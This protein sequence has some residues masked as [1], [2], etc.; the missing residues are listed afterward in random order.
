MTNTFGRLARAA[1]DV[2]GS[3]WAFTIA[4]VIVACWFLTGPVFG[5]SDTWQ[6]V[7]NTTSSVLTMLIAFLLQSS[8]NRDTR[9]LHAKLDE[10]ILYTKGADNR[11]IQA[12]DFNEQELEDLKG[13]LV[14][15][16]EKVG[17][18]EVPG[19]LPGH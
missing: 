19:N 8:Q 16:G 7:I 11:L 14:D 9:A 17:S 6:L 5:F 3:P 10:L 18:G 12:E 13:R 15:M 2:V 1:A 4:A